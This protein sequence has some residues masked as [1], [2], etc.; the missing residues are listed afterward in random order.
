MA[1][2]WRRII[3]G[4]VTV[5]MVCVASVFYAPQLLAFPFRAEIGRYHVYSESPI[6]EPAMRAV[7]A[8]ADARLAA[9]PINRPHDD[10][11]V[12]LTQG[13]SRWR[14]LSL[15]SNGAFALSRGIGRSILVNRNSIAADQ[16]EN[17]QNPGGV[18]ALSDV[19]AHEETHNL[20]RRHF[21]PLVDVTAPVWNA[22]AT[23]TSSPAAVR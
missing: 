18:R 6:P 2:F 21:G 19:I 7:L 13:G 16:V 22:K 1:R 20:L 12:F 10:I 3:L 14:L 11:A 8:R 4:A 5:A 9:S 23:A 17:G 15:T